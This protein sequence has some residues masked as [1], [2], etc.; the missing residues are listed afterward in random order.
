MHLEILLHNASK[1]LCETAHGEEPFILV[2][3]TV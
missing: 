2:Q 3:S 1:F